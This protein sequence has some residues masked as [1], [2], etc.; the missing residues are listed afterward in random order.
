MQYKLAHIII[1]ITIKELCTALM[2]QRS[3]KS[4]QFQSLF[5]MQRQIFHFN[6]SDGREKAVHWAIAHV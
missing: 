1:V 2:T 5:K 6:L 3:G 4:V